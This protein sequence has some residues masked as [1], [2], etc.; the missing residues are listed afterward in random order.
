MTFTERLDAVI[1]EL[2]DHGIT[3]VF[4][5]S[6]KT[7]GDAWVDATEKYGTRRLA[8]VHEEFGHWIENGVAFPA[9]NNGETVRRPKIWVSFDHNNPADADVIVSAFTGQ[10]FGAT[11][12]GDPFTTVEVDLSAGATR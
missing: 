7:S 4:D 5:T 6:T 2:A 11:W 12:T 1:R 8:F 3:F 10:G 9:W